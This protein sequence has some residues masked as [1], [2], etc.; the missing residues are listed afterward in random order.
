MATERWSYR[1]TEER[2][3]QLKKVKGNAFSLN[4]EL[5]TKSQVVDFALKF[6]AQ[7]LE[8]EKEKLKVD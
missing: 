1:L 5:S 6:T 7:E 8:K 3:N 2:K 4:Q